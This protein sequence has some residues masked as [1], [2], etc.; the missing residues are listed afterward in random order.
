MIDKMTHRKLTSEE[1]DVLLGNS[2]TA[3]DWNAVQVDDGFDPT[4]VKRVDFVGQVRIGGLTG[5]VISD[6]IE[7]PAGLSNATIINCS[8]GH[9][10]RVA[11]VRV[12]LANYDIGANTCIEDA[13]TLATNPGAT[14]G[15]GVA[16]DVLNEGG[17][18]EV[19]LFNELSAQFA[20]LM[21]L[22]RFHPALVERLREIA[23]A[24]TAGQRSDRGAIGDGVTVRSVNTMEDVNVGDGATI[25]GAARLRNGTVLSALDAT[26][27]VGA[28]VQAE[29][30]VF[31]ESATVADAA[32]LSACFVGQGSQIGRQ[33]SAENCLFF[34]NC[35]G[36]HGEAVSVFAGPYTVTHHKSTLLIAGLLSFYNAGSGTNQSNHM[37]KL[38]PVH[39]GKL[40]RGCKTGSFSY[41]MWPCRVGPFSVVLGKHKRNFDTSTFPFSLIEANAQGRC[42]M[43][44][45]LNLTT[46]GTV[47]D[48]AKWPARDRRKGA[49][50]R[51]RIS[52]DVLSPFTVGRMIKGSNILEKLRTETEKSVDAVTINGATVKRVLLRTGEK[53]YRTGI[54][55][56]L[57]EQIVR[58]AEQAI[59]DGRGFVEAFQVAEGAVYS[60]EWVDISG[61]LMPRQRLDSLT[62][63]VTSGSITDIDSFFAAIDQIDDNYDDDQWTWARLA[64]ERLFECDLDDLT[65]DDLGAVADALLKVRSKFLKQ[66]SA[67]AQK[68]FEDMTGFGHGGVAGDVEHDFEEVRGTYEQN[69]FVKQLQE[70][71]KALENRISKFKATLEELSQQLS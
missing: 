60:E 23:E 17:G 70:E 8:L 40:E 28:D 18:R 42:A 48:G 41:M 27:S 58:R 59:A 1:R 62:E 53:F 5:V 54:E 63:A 57:L 34:A 64:Y 33:F 51:D 39:E 31:A 67:D 66:V 21:C 35:E 61:Q 7:K 26:T 25:C 12:H 52:F 68:E 45:G 9:D 50:K 16:V 37:Y 2:C 20:H 3:T 69:T 11:N 6:G 71:L 24:Y 38:G 46:V 30:F 49:V 10:V 55:M 56:Y 43:V 65:E 14:F 44:P 32:V 47:R 15:N 29:D 36:F 4:R 22:H 13:G 19:I